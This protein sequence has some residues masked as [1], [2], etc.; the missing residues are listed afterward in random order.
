MTTSVS[1]WDDGNLL[2]LLSMRQNH[3]DD[4]VASFVESNL[5]AFFLIESFGALG[6]ASDTTIDGFVDF[7]HGD[8]IFAKANG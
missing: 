5:F 4:G 2:D 6:W 1:A 8:A 7:F 3:A